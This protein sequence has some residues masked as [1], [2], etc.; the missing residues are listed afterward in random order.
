[1]SFDDAWRWGGEEFLLC[2]KEADRIAG[3]LALER[4]RAGLEKMSVKLRDGR[5]VA[6]TASFGIVVSERTS[7]I[8]GMLEQ[9]DKALYRAKHEG[10]N[11]IV[12]A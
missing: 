10:R 2:L 4:V 7:T 8:D 12:S 5:S 6:V 9:A 11:R 1:M 3:G